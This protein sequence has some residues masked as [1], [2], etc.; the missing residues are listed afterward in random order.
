MN[1]RGNGD[2]WSSLKIRG[3]GGIVVVT[4]LTLMMAASAGRTEPIQLVNKP[5]LPEVT[6][7][8]EQYLQQ[9]AGHRPGHL[10]TRSAVTKLLNA[11]EDKG[12]QVRGQ[13]KPLERV[14][15]DDDFLV[16]QLSDEA[17]QAFLR[18]IEN[19]P[20][21]I[22]RVDR[23]SRL[24]QGE[25]SV[26]DLIR[27][28]PNGAEWIEAMTTTRRGEILGNRLSNTKA[29]RDFNE[30]TGRLYTVAALAK[31]IFDRLEPAQRATSADGDDQPDRAGK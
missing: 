22:D 16:R 11:L 8:V 17:G 14:L 21:G 10:V 26:N 27:K 19:L 23:L 15:K 1:S 4:I 5:T 13:D 9:H 30:P 12:W 25:L 28:V 20:G 18:Q 3:Q 31:E 29:G 7:F 24:P 2:G 6:Q